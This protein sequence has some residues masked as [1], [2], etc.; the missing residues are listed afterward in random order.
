[1]VALLSSINSII[2]SLIPSY[3]TLLQLPLK[4]TYTKNLLY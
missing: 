3:L 2:Y 4:F 1:M